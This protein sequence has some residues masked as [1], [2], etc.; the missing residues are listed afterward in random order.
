MLIQGRKCTDEYCIIPVRVTI[1]DRVAFLA[2]LRETGEQYN[3]TIVCLNREMI[4][5]YGHVETTLIHAL[6]SWKEE[7][8]IART[9]EMEVLLYAAGTRHTGQIGPFGPIVGVN[10]CYLCIIPPND[11]AISTLLKKMEEV[12]N[13]DWSIMSEEKKRRLISFFAITP[14]ELEITGHDRLADLISER[15]ALLTV[16][17]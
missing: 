4:A 3:V 16:N 1:D 13:E 10:N 14:K 17:R 11:Q 5:G 12:T 9:L 6:R 2:I 7:K 8:R 15:S